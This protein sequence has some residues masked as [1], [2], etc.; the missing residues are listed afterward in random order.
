MNLQN[1][2]V[3][4][5][6]LMGNMNTLRTDMFAP[7]PTAYNPG[8]FL[9][10]EQEAGMNKA[11]GYFGD[12][13]QKGIKG[14]LMSGP[15]AVIAKYSHQLGEEQGAI[16]KGAVA[17]GG[18]TASGDSTLS[19]K[20]AMASLLTG[21]GRGANAVGVS[22]MKGAQLLK[23]FETGTQ[24][25]EA[26]KGSREFQSKLQYDHA[27]REAEKQ[28]MIN[29]REAA[30]SASDG[31]ALGGMIGTVAG[32]AIG[33][34]LAVPTGGTSLLAGGALSQAGMGAAMLG[35]AATGGALG[36]MGGGLLGGMM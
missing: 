14:E 26:V 2:G 34:A 6:S 31:G 7:M 11:Y 20:D 29:N 3:M 18:K 17:A 16:E 8:T 28:Q 27:V 33:A 15:Q 9:S 23:Q 4:A 19:G 1:L 12:I 35:G 5:G 10:P 24:G 36:G 30:E 13:R 22:K 25:L 32:M 21:K